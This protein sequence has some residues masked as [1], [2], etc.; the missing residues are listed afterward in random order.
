V[1]KGESQW[2]G[3]WLAALLCLVLA[4]VKLALALLWSLWRVLLPLW[5]MLWHNGVYMAVGFHVVDV[6]GDAGGKAITSGFGQH[7]K[8]DRYQSGTRV[9]RDLPGQ[10]AEKDWRGGE[11][12]AVLA[13][14]GQTCRPLALWRIDARVKTRS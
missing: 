10:R 2:A 4:V 7:P 12:Q 6:D 9:R 11:I 13:G 5:M 14:F 8:L 3:F 1:K